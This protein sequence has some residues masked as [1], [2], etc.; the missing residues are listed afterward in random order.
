MQNSPY[1]YSVII[2]HHDIPDLL[3]RCLRSIPVRDDVQV[4]VVDDASAPEHQDRLHQLEL[5]FPGAEFIYSPS[6]RG[7]GAARN[8]GLE[9][10]TG[11]W[12]IFADADDFFVENFGEILDEYLAEHEDIIYFRAICVSSDNTSEV[13]RRSSVSFFDEVFDRYI[14]SGDDSE[15]R[16][17]IVSPWAKLFRREFVSNSAL[18][19]EE[20]PYSNDVYFD[21]AAGCSASSVKAV[22]EVVYCY[23]LRDGSLTSAF[24]DKPGELRV[25]AEVCY[26][27]QKIMK[28]HGY[29]FHFMP[30]TEYMSIMFHTDK[31]MFREFLKK[32]PDIY[33]S[34]V[35][36][37]RQIRWWENGLIPK[38]RVVAYSVLCI[39][40]DF[41]RPQTWPAQ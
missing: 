6:N 22:N 23:T 18:R 7:A 3:E 40:S 26:R 5:A 35:D 14:A 2:P 30:M 25:R 32:A 37:I 17:A 29:K 21:V 33:E 27:A 1:N 34:K 9:H 10:A 41:V 39:I 19:F 36:A 4:I 11:K 28:E 13:V 24:A 15:L 16:C 20:T 12:L 8:I 38:L 31:Q